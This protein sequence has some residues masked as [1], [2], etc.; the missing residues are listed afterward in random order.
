M[1]SPIFSYFAVL[2]KRN[3]Y[4]KYQNHEKSKDHPVLFY[5]PGVYV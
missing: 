3:K 5:F 2:V 4:P 1:Y